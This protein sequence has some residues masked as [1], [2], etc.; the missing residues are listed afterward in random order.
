MVATGWPVGDRAALP[1]VE[2]LYRGLAAG[3]TASAA[4]REAKLAAIRRGAP[5]RE[6]AAFT[7]IGDPSV[8]VPLQPPRAGWLSLW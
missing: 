3:R 8:R 4:L 6:W 2:D 5:A 1:M 7:L